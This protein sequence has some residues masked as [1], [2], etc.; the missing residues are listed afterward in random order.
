MAFRLDRSY[1]LLLRVFFPF[2]IPWARHCVFGVSRY[3]DHV[4][5]F[6]N[7]KLVRSLTEI[8][9][10]M[11]IATLELVS[12]VALVVAGGARESERER[13]IDCCALASS[14]WRRRIVRN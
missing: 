11:D 9:G 2:H 13:R 12:S 8:D 4:Q 6:T 1:C 3:C 10:W 14:L 7:A 5:V